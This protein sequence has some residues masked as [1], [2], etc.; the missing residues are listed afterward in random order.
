[1]AKGQKVPGFHP[2]RS[3]PAHPSLS[4]LNMNKMLDLIQQTNPNQTNPNQDFMT[5]VH[6]CHAEEERRLR[7]DPREKHLLI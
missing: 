7:R 4:V 3:E 2:K 5:T 6:N 1:M